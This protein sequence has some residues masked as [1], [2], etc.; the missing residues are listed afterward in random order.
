M[1]TETPSTE[2]AIPFRGFK[3]WYRIVGSRE[4][5]W[6]DSRSCVCMAAPVSHTITLSLLR[7]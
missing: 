1:S 7:R 2:G 5:P 6:Q 3:T 4:D